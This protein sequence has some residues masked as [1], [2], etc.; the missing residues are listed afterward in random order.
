VKK[1][2]TYGAWSWMSVRDWGRKR[3]DIKELDA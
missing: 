3:K 2:H 1:Q